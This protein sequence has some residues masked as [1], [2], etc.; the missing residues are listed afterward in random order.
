MPGIVDNLPLPIEETEQ[1]R[2]ARKELADSY[3]KNPVVLTPEQQEF[4]DTKFCSKLWRLDNLYTIQPKS[5]PK[6]IMKLNGA[7]RK[8]LQQYKHLRKIILK[9][10]QTGVSTLYLAY[11]LDDCIT[12]PGFNA[13]IQSYGQ[14]ESDKLAERARLMWEDLDPNVKGMLGVKL[15]SDNAKGMMFSNG[16]ILK[17]GNFRGDTLQSLHVSE[18]AKIAKRYPEKAEEIK[19]G[20]FQAVSSDNRITVEGTAEGPFGM[21]FEM[22]ELAYAIQKAGHKHSPLEFQAIFISWLEDPDCNMADTP[23][24]PDNKQY[25]LRDLEIYWEGLE[26]KL[27]IILEASQKNW[28]L[29]K[30]LEL[31]SKMKQEYP[32]TPEEAFEQSIEGT[33]YKVQYEAMLMEG[34]LGSFTVYKGWPIDVVFDL[35]IN[36]EFFILFGQQQQDR[37]L[38]FAEYSNTGQGLDFYVAIINALCEK[39]GVEVRYVFAPHDIS[40]KEL[41]T[42][43]TRLE[44]LNSLGVN[45]Q[46]LPKLS[47]VDGINAVKEFLKVAYI[48]YECK[49]LILAIQNYRK[50]YD[51]KLGMYLDRPVHDKFSH[52][53]DCLR[54]FSTGIT[55]YLIDS[56]DPHSYTSSTYSSQSAFNNVIDG[57]A[58]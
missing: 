22:W 3:V 35:G 23:F 57:M 17:I 38:I 27:G 54:Y 37:Y 56:Y 24:V 25:I 45:P 29:A 40:V 8:I 55:S 32:A 28:Y 49:N 7:Q 21:F 2:Q 53:T 44:V 31:A 30:K 19:T 42:G 46:V 6:K 1:E 34:R 4:L 47:I 13:G 33:Y 39:M 51:E 43:R 9:I 58:L 12:I 10:R 14:D 48:D 5:G 18:L 52:A 50:Q 36:D 20:A 41:G 15:I 16:S 11:N 26:K